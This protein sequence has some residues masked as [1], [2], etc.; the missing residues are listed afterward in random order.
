MWQI[1]IC[2]R[3]NQYSEVHLI[4]PKNVPHWGLNL[5]LSTNQ[6]AS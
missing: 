2:F 3:L 1:F 5:Y 6:S 4:Y